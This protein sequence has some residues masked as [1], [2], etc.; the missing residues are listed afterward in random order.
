MFPHLSHFSPKYNV[1]P[2]KTAKSNGNCLLLRKL[3]QKNEN[4]VR[5]RCA[6]AQKLELYCTAEHCPRTRLC[7]T[8]RYAMTLGQC[9]L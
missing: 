2:G 9:I 4:S 8:A 5:L 6:A 7:R 1:P 3:L